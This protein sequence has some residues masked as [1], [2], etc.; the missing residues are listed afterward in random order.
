MRDDHS[1]TRKVEQGVLQRLQGL[2]IKIIGWLVEQQQVAA[3]LQGQ[4]QVQPVPLAAGEDARGLL[5]VRPLE[6]ER[7]DVRPRRHF[8]VA[9]F[10]VVE[11]V[12]HQLPDIFARI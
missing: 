1:T 10:D 12:G 7:G 8:E 11:A 4:G 2:D 5:L 3:H 6:A 9:N